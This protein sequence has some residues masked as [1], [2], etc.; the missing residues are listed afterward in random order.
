MAL[1]CHRFPV[2]Y[3]MHKTKVQFAHLFEAAMIFKGKNVLTEHQEKH[4][5]IFK[6][7]I[8]LKISF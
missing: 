6:S 1:T 7:V 8:L 5:S 2:L 4:I 3:T